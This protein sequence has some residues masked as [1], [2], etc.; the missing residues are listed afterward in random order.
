LGLFKCTK[1][2]NDLYQRIYQVL[3]KYRLTYV[4][5]VPHK[6]KQMKT[7]F[8]KFIVCLNCS[9]LTV[10][11]NAIFFSKGFMRMLGTLVQVATGSVIDLV[12]L[13]TI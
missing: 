3:K 11:T 2:Y 13:G 4:P 10:E 12:H 1:W 6:S 8:R 5:N 7:F 9:G